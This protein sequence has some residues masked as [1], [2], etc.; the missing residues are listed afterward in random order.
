MDSE[1][2]EV[3]KRLQVMYE[4]MQQSGDCQDLENAIFEYEDCVTPEDYAAWKE[5][6]SFFL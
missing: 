3:Y 2:E 4:I 1:A 6:Y 5:K